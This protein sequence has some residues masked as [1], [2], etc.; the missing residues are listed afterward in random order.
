VTD[1]VSFIGGMS[2]PSYAG[3]R[4]NASIPLAELTIHDLALHWRARGLGRLLF[5]VVL[6]PDLLKIDLDDV[7]AAF[8]LRGEWLTC[9]VGFVLA[10]GRE[11]NF[12]TRRH[13]D[14]VLREVAARGVT[15]DPSPRSAL[16]FRTRRHSVA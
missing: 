2:I 1:P 6:S 4:A 9:G 14:A 16:W 10:D 12:W 11:Y 8:R 13:R 5:A 3:W 15:V 7:V